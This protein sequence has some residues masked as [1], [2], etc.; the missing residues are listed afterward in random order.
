MCCEIQIMVQFAPMEIKEYELAGIETIARG[1][2]V[3]DGK[4]LLCDG[5]AIRAF[6]SGLPPAPTLV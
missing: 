2:C 3:R 4:L 5:I 1:V 6:E